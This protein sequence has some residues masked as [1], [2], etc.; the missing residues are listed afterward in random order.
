[1]LMLVQCKRFTYD[2][3]A[4][5]FR[6]IAPTSIHAGGYHWFYGWIRDMEREGMIGTESIE[7]LENADLRGFEGEYTGR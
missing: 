2:A 7:V 4:G 6:F 1:M 5:T 3:H